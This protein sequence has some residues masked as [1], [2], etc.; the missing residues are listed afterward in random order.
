MNDTLKQIEENHSFEISQILKTLGWKNI[1]NGW[2]CIISEFIT[3]IL[4]I[5]GCYLSFDYKFLLGKLVSINLSLF[6]TI[7]GFFA[8][9]QAFYLVTEKDDLVEKQ[10]KKRDFSAKTLYQTYWAFIS[11]LILT[12]TLVTVVSFVLSFLLDEKINIPK[13]FPSC[14]FNFAFHSIFFLSLYCICLIYEAVESAFAISQVRSLILV[15][16]EY[17]KFEFQ[18]EYESKNPGK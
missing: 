17:D 7:I 10:F 4:F 3:I 14:V 5:I 2:V 8:A 12:S 13:D 6:P 18:K 11:F 1:L 15:R 9:S 16:K